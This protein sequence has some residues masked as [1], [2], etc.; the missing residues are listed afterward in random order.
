MLPQ[1]LIALTSISEV[2]DVSVGPEQARG[3]PM[4]EAP[5]SEVTVYSDRA[6]I[7]RK[8]TVQL[9]AGTHVVRWP[10]LPGA[11][12][13]D[14][15]RASASGAKILRIE[16]APVDRERVSIEQAD[17]LLVRL[18]KLADEI[19]L[20]DAESEVTGAIVRM[21]SEI[22]PAPPVP[23][24]Q[25]E[26]R[27]A[28]QLAPEIWRRALDFLAKERAKGR[29]RLRAIAEERR[30]KLEQVQ[31]LQREIQ[32]LD[33]GGFS[34]RRL[35]TLTVFEL[36]AA[37]RVEAE[38]EYFLHGASW[39]PSYD[40]H[41]DP[42]QGKVRIE[43]RGG[44]TQ[45]TGEDWPDVTLDLSTAIPGQNI[46][47]PELLTWTLG[48]AKELIPQPRAKTPPPPTPMHPPP[49][50]SPTKEE[51]E[52][53][54][55]RALLEQRLGELRT[56]AAVDPSSAVAYQKQ[57]AIDFSEL[58]LDGELLT[59]QGSIGSVGS[60]RIG[61]GAGNLSSVPGAKSQGQPVPTRPPPPPPAAPPPREEA[62]AES[63]T[64]EIS[65][66]RPTAGRSFGSAARADSDEG[67]VAPTSLALFDSPPPPRQS[68]A[69]QTLPAVLAGGL[70]YVYRAAARM[71]VPSTGE[72]LRA[73]LGAETYPVSTYY[74]AAPG[75]SPTAYLEA[76]VVNQS[77]RPILMGSINIFVGG[78]FV[79]EATMKTTGP[80]GKIELPL[81][82]D[83]DIRLLR[84]VIPTTETSGLFSKHEITH[85]KVVIEVVN[86]KKRAVRVGIREP[87]PKTRN[88]DIEISLLKTTPKPAQGPDAEGVI[89][90]VL[91][92]GAGKKQT[93]ELEY[94]V[95]RPAD[96]QLYQQ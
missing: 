19:S 8:A 93:I 9:A 21:L 4:I 18:E 71:T 69:D 52:L 73:P 92:V 82:A 60:G 30:T 44:V 62:Y 78:K 22:A 46:A 26:G 7:R 85:Y 80:G 11:T 57:T 49:Q 6:R 10:D 70:D 50:P 23:E 87:L 64:V 88:E 25:R 39:K 95:D 66:A 75:L 54:A 13:L 56:V 79:G 15:L 74:E 38:L 76:T 68:F 96:F 20:L 31:S 86:H 42:E 59:P 16:A 40:L 61:L 89:L 27:P 47:I 94:K 12:L 2:P 72:L 43:T 48:E 67:Y 37:G 14:T 29:E 77:K 55:R 36:S 24:A 65:S 34:D 45:A 32:Q 53:S 91:D 81:G 28:P 51:Q 3:A 83:E 41:F 17:Q 58:H 1:L 33:L 90:W 5:I 84:K 63:D 35:Q